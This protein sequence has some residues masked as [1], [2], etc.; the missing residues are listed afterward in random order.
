MLSGRSWLAAALA[1]AAW[2]GTP[3]FEAPAREQIA[4]EALRLAP[5]SL[6]R[7]LSRRS[8]ALVR[9]AR[10]EAPSTLD[11]AVRRLGAEIDTAVALINGRKS[12]R[13]ITESL[14]RLAGVAACLNNPL[15]STPEGGDVRDAAQF[16]SFLA[17]NVRRFP[18]VF[19]G[20]DAELQKGGD[21][22]AF[23]SRIRERYLADRVTLHRA[24]HPPDGGPILPSDFDE[25][26]VPF[27]IAS[28]CYSRAVTD[29]SQLWIH[30]W[31]R[32]DG[33]LSGTPYLAPTGENHP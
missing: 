14:G 23:A 19:T 32:A 8:Q 26:S 17:Q 4:L 33:D 25:R 9:G 24:Y 2:S 21:V 3:A 31:R 20:Y 11:N 10:E 29:A 13:S 27:A 30:V 18:L 15:W 16:S 7:Q 12:F 6:R 1:F 22:A 5:P 28:L